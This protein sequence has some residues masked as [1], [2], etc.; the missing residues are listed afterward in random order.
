MQAMQLDA[1]PRQTS[2]EPTQSTPFVR[3]S[4]DNGNVHW[5]CHQ[6]DHNANLIWIECQFANISDQP[7]EAC[8]RVTISDDKDQEIA[9]SRIVC[10]DMM[11][12]NG[13]YEN[14]ASFQNSRANRTRDE[15]RIKCG[16]D[17]AFCK[18][19]TKE[20]PRE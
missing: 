7:H 8:F 20:V 6:E 4:S 16:E 13:T 19:G 2:E 17:L 5:D 1:V 11:V 3:T 9:N 18:L 12:P 10:S 14:Y 15:I